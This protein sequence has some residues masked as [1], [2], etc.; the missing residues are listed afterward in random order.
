MG[1]LQYCYLDLSCFIADFDEYK[2]PII[3]HL[4]E[5]KY[6]HWDQSIREL[7][8]Q[9]LFKLTSCCPDYMAFSVLPKL[10]KYSF[11]IDLNTRHGSL[12]SLAELVHALC[13][14]AKKRNTSNLIAELKR[15]FPN[16]I[17]SELKIVLGKIFEEKYFRGTG[18]ELMR[19][20][21]CFVLKKLS[22]A[23]LFQQENDDAKKDSSEQ[24]EFLFNL[25]KKF[26]EE[27]ETFLNQCIEYN[28][29]SVQAAAAETISF[30]CDLNF[31]K[32]KLA[33]NYLN[34]NMLKETKLVNIYL[35]NL[36]STSK[37]HI[38]SGYC[39]ALSNLPIYLLGVNNHYEAIIKDLIIASKW[40]SGIILSF[41]IWL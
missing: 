29:E 41:L 6:N 35:T 8:S 20:A 39:L 7:T 33:S 28:K 36:K 38:R 5:H 37:E 17:V 25:E 2:Q 18:G 21:V 22:I 11:S 3:D 32:F 31:F 16:E 15:F 1:Q 27:S 14:E 40:K 9:A 19:P 24:E 26:L 12:I 10:L 34:E 30:Y 23:K 13:E 4:L